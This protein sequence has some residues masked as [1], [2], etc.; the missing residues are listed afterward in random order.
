MYDT[1]MKLG[2][3][4][5]EARK[6]TERLLAGEAVAMTCVGCGG[7]LEPAKDRRRREAPTIWR[8]ALWHQ[9]CR[10]AR[11]WDARCRALAFERGERV[12]VRDRDEADLYRLVDPRTR[13]G[14]AGTA[15]G[16]VGEVVGWHRSGGRFPMYEVAGGGWVA[17]V[18]A[19]VLERVGEG[20]VG[21]R[22]N[23]QAEP[24]LVAD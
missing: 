5:P 11:A 22:A 7:A 4:G 23:G 1:W 6:I 19:R 15:R 13:Q 14:L 17:I 12:R 18:P 9:G 3:H 8:G 16:R 24:G 20:V 10:K 21:E 2:L